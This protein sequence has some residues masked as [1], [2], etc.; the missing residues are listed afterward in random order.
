MV[1]VVHLAYYLYSGA[2]F[3]LFLGG[4]GGQIF[5]LFFNSTG[6]FKNLKKQHF[7]CSNLTLFIVPF[8]LSFFFLF[9]SFFSLFFLFFLSFFSFFF[10][11]LG[12]NGPPAPLPNDASVYIIIPEALFSV[13]P[14][15]PVIC[16]SVLIR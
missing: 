3:Q 9:F 12:G 2:S 13:Q 10:F 7:I 5:F 8:F 15:R 1:F 14:C 4:G 6:L 16:H 11:F